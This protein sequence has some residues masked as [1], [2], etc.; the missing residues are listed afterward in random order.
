MPFIILRNDIVD[1]QV[2]AIVNSTSRDGYY[3]G[4]AE[5]SMMMIAGEELQQDRNDLGIIKVTEAKIS[6]GY[7]LKSKYVIHTVGPF[8][9][10]ETPDYLLLSNTYSNVLKKAL[11]AGCE[12][13]AFPLIST[14]LLGYPKKLA[15]RIAEA[16]IKD[17]LTEYDMNI[18]LLVYDNESYLSSVELFN[19][20]TEYLDDNL[21]SKADMRMFNASIMHKKMSDSFQDYINLENRLTDIDEGFSKTL[22]KLVECSGEKTVTI[23]S[24][25]NVDKKL[26]S[27]IKNDEN[28]HPSKNIAIAFAIALNLNLEETEDFLERA[29]YALSK[30]IVFD[31]IIEY[32]IINEIHDIFTVNEILYDKDQRLLGS[33]ME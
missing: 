5:A 22:M 4:G 21:E 11:E 1:M 10:N 29:G 3:S 25:A 31:V 15:L 13:I 18:Y 16:V 8:F 33:S 17:F 24:K 2:D 23:Y 20:V 9:E 6:K 19:N 26:F 30:S 12:S 32:C 7:N 27:K 28:Y 14:G